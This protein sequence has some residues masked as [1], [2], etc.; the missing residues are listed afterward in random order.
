MDNASKI[1]KLAFVMDGLG[2][3]YM[4]PTRTTLKG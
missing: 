3:T 1:A 2:A 4:D